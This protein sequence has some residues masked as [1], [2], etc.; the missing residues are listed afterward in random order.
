MGSAHAVR[1]PVL[2]GPGDDCC[3]G[4]VVPAE[5][6]G[7]GVA[8]LERERGVEH[9]GGGEPVMEPA[10]LL[11]EILGDGVH[12]GGDVVLGLG[13]ELGDA[14]RGGRHRAGADRLDRLGGNRAHGRPAVERGELHFEPASE[15]RLVRPEE[16]VM[17]GRE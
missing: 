10:A 9:V 2:L 3:K 17:A 12:E 1:L 5:D 13:L 7:A 4:A 15:L 6:Q 14:L 11:A 16:A 8:D